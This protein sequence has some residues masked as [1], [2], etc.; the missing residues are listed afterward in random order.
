M[1][2][3]ISPPIPVYPEKVGIITAEQGAALQDFL[4]IYRRRCLWMDITLISVPV[5]GE[6]A[7]PAIIEALRLASNY[8]FDVIVL[9]RGG[10]SMEDLWAFNDESLARAI[11]QC[12]IPIIS[13]VGP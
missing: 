9:T 12:S 3:I 10:G 4:K 5:Q 2:W 11:S 1:I 13:A 8:K 6:K 7:P